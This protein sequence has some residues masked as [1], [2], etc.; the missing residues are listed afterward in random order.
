M[1]EQ[2]KMIAPCIFGIESIAA[3][4]FKRMGFEYVKVENGRVLLEGDC[5]LLARANINSRFAERILIN[6]GQFKALNFTELFDNVADIAWENFIGKYDSFPV[7]GSSIDSQLHS[8]PDCQ[9]IIKK[10]VVS[11][12]S[13]KYGISWF[14]ETGPE[15]KIK[16]TI[17]KDNVT[18]MIDTSGEGLHKR[19]YRKNSNNA[20]LKETLAAAMC[21]LARIYPD[22]KI[23][24]PFCGSGTILIESA[25]MAAKIAPGLNRY[26]AADRFE[27]IPKKVWQEERRRARDLIKSDVS[28]EGIGYDID[29]SCVELTAQNARKAGVSKYIKTFQKDIKNITIPD[30]R[31]IVVTNPPYGERLL[32]LKAAEEIYKVMGEKFKIESGKKYFIISPHDDFERFFGSTADKRRKLYN[33]MIKCQLFMYFR[34]NHFGPE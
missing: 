1:N 27:F 26:F 18:I 30:E 2:I 31:L 32:D 14:E 34:N 17:I 23:I 21:D 13:A 9:S 10:A 19:G 25:M 22:T 3:N 11:R 29:N 4:E 12:L 8:I 20:P 5:N 33:G 24:D 15:Y 7:T 16:F 6:L 28:F